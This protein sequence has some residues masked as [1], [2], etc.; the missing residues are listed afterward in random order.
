MILLNKYPQNVG[1]TYRWSRKI[2]PHV[3]QVTDRQTDRA[4]YRKVSLPKKVKKMNI[5]FTKEI[6]VGE[7]DYVCGL[8]ELP[9]HVEG[10]E[11]VLLT[12]LV[13]VF[14]VKD[15]VAHPEFRS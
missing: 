3:K 4:G 6:V 9:R 1:P 14:N 2:G 8:V 7:E 11:A 13:Q 15:V 12:Q 10:A 5:F